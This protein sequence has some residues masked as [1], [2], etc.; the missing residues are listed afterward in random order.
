VS[1]G[2]KKRKKKKSQKKGQEAKSELRKRH[3]TS[4]EKTSLDARRTRT[5]TSEWS[6][7]GWEGNDLKVGC[8]VGDGGVSG[9]LL[10]ALG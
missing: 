10:S 6:G 5:K 9:D 7:C 1:K 8:R 3:R 2:G 4:L